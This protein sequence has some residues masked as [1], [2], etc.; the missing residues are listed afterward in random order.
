MK[1]GRISCDMRPVLYLR[2]FV[3]V[4]YLPRIRDAAI[5][6]TRLLMR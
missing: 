6:D 5:P 2:F 1:T 3:F 4:C